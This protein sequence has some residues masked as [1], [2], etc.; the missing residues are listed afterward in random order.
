LILTCT[1]ELSR[2]R[3]VGLK[4]AQG[5]SLPK[6]LQELGHVAEGV[7]TAREAMQ[8]ADQLGVDMPITAAVKHILFDN[9]PARQAVEA[10]LS[11][12]QK[13]EN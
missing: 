11:R 1:G 4:L 3:Q 9:L 8:L 10:L 13:N 2:N 7:N 6:A 5:K 12:S